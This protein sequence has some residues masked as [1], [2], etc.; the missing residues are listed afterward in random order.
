LL[1]AGCSKSAPA[2]TSETASASFA[3]AIDEASAASL[4]G[5]VSSLAFSPADVTRVR[6]DVKETSTGTLVYENFDL[7]KT[8][9]VWSGTLPFLPKGKTITFLAKAYAGTTLLFS[10]S[11]DQTLTG[12]NQ[13]VTIALAP[14]NDGQQI[15][16]P[17]ITRITIPEFF[18]EDK[19]GN[20]SFSV[21]ATTGEKLSY[22]ITGAAGGGTFVPQRGT[23]TL[24]ATA[25]TFVSQYNPP[26]VAEETEYTHEVTVTNQAGHSVT[27]TFKTKVKPIAHDDALE[28]LIKVVF[29]PVINAI[30]AHRPVDTSDVLWKATVADDAPLAQLT[31][32]W[33]FTAT[34]TFDPA[35][36]FT[37]ATTNPVRMLNYTPLLQGE[38]K[39]TVT[40]AQ[41]GKTTLTYALTPDQF[42]DD[43]Y[44]VGDLG[45][46]QSI[47]TGAHHTCVLLD[48]AYVR[49]WGY[50]A[51][52]QLGTNST[53]SIGDNEH[54]DSIGNINLVGN[55]IQVVTG[56][57]HTCAL[58][59]TGFVRCWG[60][61]TYGQLGYGNT[62][63]VG[64]GEPVSSQG[65]V[66]LG[67]RATR[68][69]AG[70][71]HTCAVLTTGKVRCWGLN[72]HGQLG[73]G[74]KTNVGDTKAVWTA[75]DVSVSPVGERVKDIV[76]G[77]YHT[78]ALLESG[79][80]RCWG[81]N[82]AGQLGHG[83]TTPIGDTEHPSSVG[84]VIVG[85]PVK[86]LSAGYFNTC[87][88]L[89]TGNVRCWGYNYSG[90]LGY[91][92]YQI[93]G[94]NET[95]ASVGDVNV[96]ETVLQIVTSETDDE[97]WG[98]G[99]TCALLS[100]GGVKCWGYNG[101][102]ELGYGNTT[103]LNQPPAATVDLSGASA[104]ALSVGAHHTCA[105]LNT[106]K[107]R[108]WGYNRDGQLGYSHT[109]SVGDNEQPSW[110]GDIRLP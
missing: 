94:D 14:K 95:P 46:L 28:P 66:N 106:G 86:Q 88:L 15:T 93:I 51:Y 52:G 27:T 16:L 78:C 4:P 87:A 33:K 25:A 105:L 83:N 1:A 84:E 57:Y 43:F 5:R 32:E 74:H 61:N 60:Q 35:P 36:E 24:L 42:P 41:N 98:V 22:V 45:G 99:F 71:S 101:N 9:G 38:L 72:N 67:G 91:G 19:R 34:G 8:D 82:D 77:G 58:L 68:L 110:A 53:Q 81:R 104:Y 90:Q 50:N 20:V 23:I 6:I 85:G 10:G 70:L 64:D 29:N 13:T 92:H 44:D 17:R 100:T 40:D 3:I 21:S 63:N 11:T 31:Y 107:A 80:V 76:A 59:D 30:A 102:G 69:A 2:Q 55:A 73:Y 65:Y 89:E 47:S 79:N 75:G 39:L 97:R 108:C 109:A 37:D 54:P 62:E 12:N 26:D 18:P 56:G 7:I 49:C 103:Q 96:G 48:N